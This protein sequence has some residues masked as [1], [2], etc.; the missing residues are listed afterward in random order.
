M[1]ADLLG[2]SGGGTVLAVGVV[3]LVT[4]AIH[5]ATG[6]A[7][8]LLMA[9]FIAPIVGTNQVVPVMTIALLVSHS[10]RTL[11]NI[12]HM[13]VRAFLNVVVPALPFI[14][15]V[16]FQYRNFS[17]TVVAFLMGTILV[18]SV[19]IRRLARHRKVRAGPRALRGAGAV[20]GTL[21][22]AAVGPGIFLVPFLLGHGLVRESFVATLAAVALLTNAVRLGLFGVT[23]LYTP[24]TVRL[25]LF[26][27]LLTIPGNWLGR[28]ILR[29]M[30]NESHV[31]VV[32]VLVLLGAC[33]FYYLGVRELL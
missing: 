30:S 31:I 26:I 6:L 32:E 24:E 19:P 29:R 28:A 20:Y 18:A 8:G 11:L 9:A 33:Q 16:A 12:R 23:D 17:G 25:A 15:L 3:A 1:I 7:G 4:A 27:G 10:T 14:A 22:G 2:L 13:D 21:A 5:G